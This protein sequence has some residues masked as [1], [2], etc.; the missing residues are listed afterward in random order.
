MNIPK[1]SSNL[2]EVITSVHRRRRWAA[3][4]ERA[5]VEEAEQPGASVSS[6]ARKNGVD[7]NQLFHWRRLIGQGSLFA[8]N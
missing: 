6:V 7:L 5:L 2:I 1:P 8:V 4:E 3:E